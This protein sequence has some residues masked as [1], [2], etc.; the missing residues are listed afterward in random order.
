MPN[1]DVFFYM[2]S[3]FQM[4]KLF[5]ALGILML[6]PLAAGA[7]TLWNDTTFVAPFTDG[8]IAVSTDIDNASNQKTGVR[9]I[10]DY[11]E[12]WFAGTGAC[13]CEVFATVEEEV[14]P[15]VWVPI[16]NQFT[17]YR[18][19]DLTRIIQYD[20]QFVSNPGGDLSI[21][22]PDGSDIRIS[23]T[24]GHAPPTMRLVMSLRE[25]TPGAVDSINMSA[26]SVL[27]HAGQ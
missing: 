9:V 14:A 10:V 7:S 6:F 11:D 27:Y 19:G 8:I 16:A 24:T 12:I 21:E 18:I 25:F 17:A 13:P 23:V 2:G 3:W 15:D 26:F 1:T 20:P 4:N 22:Q 5:V